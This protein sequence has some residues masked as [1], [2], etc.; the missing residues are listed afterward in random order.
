MDEGANGKSVGRWTNLW[1]FD[2]ESGKET[3]LT[4][5]ELII[6]EFDI[7]PDDKTIVF[8]AR[9]DNRQN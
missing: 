2:P 1:Q 3:M 4:N 9:P 8:S 5:E 7:A 6:E